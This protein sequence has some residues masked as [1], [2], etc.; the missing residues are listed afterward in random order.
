MSEHKL[1]HHSEE[2]HGEHNHKEHNHK[3]THRT[4][5]HTHNHAHI[6]GADK[7]ILTAFFLNLFFVF[8]EIIGGFLTNSFAIL[9]DAVHDFGDCAAIG[10]A[11]LMEKLSNKAPDEKYTYGY[12]R[13]SLLSAIIT[14][15]ILIVGSV[16]VIVGAVGRISQP[17]EVQGLGMIIIAVFGVLINGVAVIKTHKGTGVNERAISLHLLEDVLGWIAVLIGSF[18]V[19]FF[20]WY[21]IDG[22]LSVLIAGF[23]LFESTKNIKEIFVILLEKTPDEVDVVAFRKEVSAIDGVKDIHHLHIWSLDGEKIMATAHIRL[24]SNATMEL[25]KAVKKTVES[26]SRKHGIEHLTVQMD[27][28]CEECKPLCDL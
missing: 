17:K 15:A 12:R 3:H 23:L 21:F 5:N 13:Y 18:F 4:H 2:C 20:K 27:L 22:L 16:F 10:F 7:N 11:Y 9:S 6:H 25:Y 24:E 19:Y 1:H 14:S 26:I 28:N 8:V